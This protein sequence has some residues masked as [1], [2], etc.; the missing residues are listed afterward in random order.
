[1]MNSKT[2][3]IAARLHCAPISIP[4]EYEGRARDLAATYVKKFSL[5]GLYVLDYS[6]VYNRV[7]NLTHSQLTANPEFNIDT[8][9]HFINANTLFYSVTDIQT[10]V[11]SYK[12]NPEEAF[13]Y[14]ICFF[15]RKLVSFKRRKIAYIKGLEHEDIDQAM[16]IAL[17]R[18]LERY[19]PKLPFS[20][21]YLDLE[22]FAAVTQLGGEMRT[23]P[24]PRNDFVNYLK[25]SYYIDKYMLT[26]ENIKQFLYEINLPEAAHV[27]TQLPFSIDEKDRTYSCKI[28]L[29]KAYD[30]FTLYSIEHLG[31]TRAISYDDKSDIIIDN[32]GVWIEPGFEAVELDLFARQ[33]FHDP[34]EQRIFYRLTQP[35][36]TTF[37]SKELLE[38]YEYTRYALAKMKE[39]IKIA[40]Q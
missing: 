14:I 16:M 18:V 7:C 35:G 11:L 21:T 29:R 4:K 19:N 20:F 22:L 26:P 24:L 9:S 15:A 10:L 32:T 39:K 2:D 38:E 27:E 25:F 23:F 37:S 28:T 31:I 40:L 12:T 13:A 3:S 36:G 17:Y 6:I 5:S 30:Y 8:F 34:K 1:M 33:A